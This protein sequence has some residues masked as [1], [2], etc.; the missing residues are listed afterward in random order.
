M[1]FCFIL[2]M[3]DVKVFDY[4][5]FR[6]FTFKGSFSSEIFKVIFN[7]ASALNIDGGV[8]NIQGEK[9]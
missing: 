1:N 3:R 6:Y 4:S 7:E 2:L 9:F 8:L 5:R